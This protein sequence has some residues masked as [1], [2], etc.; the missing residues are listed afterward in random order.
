MYSG[1]GIILLASF[2][3]YP[4]YLIFFGFLFFC[5]TKGISL[6]QPLMVL[7]NDFHKTVLKKGFMAGLLAALLFVLLVLAGF[8]L[9]REQ[10]I[11]FNIERLVGVIVRIAFL[12]FFAPIAYRL[13]LPI[14]PHHKVAKGLLAVALAYSPLIVFSFLYGAYRSL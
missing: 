13:L 12:L 7:P 10:R 1:G 2:V 3:A 14:K 4:V 6:F 11:D 8:L 9:P 5:I